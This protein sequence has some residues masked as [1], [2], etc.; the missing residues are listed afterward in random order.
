[1]AKI[2]LLVDKQ[3]NSQSIVK[4]ITGSACV[5]AD[6]FLTDALG[7]VASDVKTEEYEGV[8]LF[9]TV[10]ETTGVQAVRR[11]INHID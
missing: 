1:M 3:G 4:G 11:N 10:S 6:K 5:Q 2:I 9:G 8:S 7:E